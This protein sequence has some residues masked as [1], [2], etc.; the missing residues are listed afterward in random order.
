[1]RATLA[2]SGIGPPG[3]ISRSV[4]DKMSTL[5]RKVLPFE[6]GLSGMCGVRQAKNLDTTRIISKQLEVCGHEGLTFEL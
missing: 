3:S 6:K 4:D 1:M 2:G 5:V